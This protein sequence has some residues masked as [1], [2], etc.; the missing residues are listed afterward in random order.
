MHFFAIV[1][2]SSVLKFSCVVH[3]PRLLRPVLACSCEKITIFRG[4]HKC[5]RH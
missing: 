2:L 5:N 3:T 1:T 4:A